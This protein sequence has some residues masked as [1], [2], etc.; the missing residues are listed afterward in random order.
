MQ[1]LSLWRRPVDAKKITI[2]RR[3]TQAVFFGITGTWLAVGAL[4]CPYGIPFISCQSCPSTDCPGR[5]LQLP[6]IGLV[7]LSG[8]LFGRA[9]CGWVCPMGFLMDILGKIP[10]LRFTISERFAAVDRYLKPL[11]YV[12]L[13]ATVYLVFALNYPVDRPYDYVVR[14]ESVFNMEAIRIGQLLGSSVYTVHMW[15]LIGALVGGLVIS[16]FWCRYLCP[17][18]ALLGLLNKVSLFGIIREREDLPRCALYPRDCNMHTMPGTTDCIVC[19]EC[20]EACPRNILG[21]RARYWGRRGAAG[22]ETPADEEQ[23]PAR[24]AQ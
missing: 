9:F 15:I 3:I 19:G 20:V 5:Y 17:L 7:A 16:R 2:W 11:K 13:A 6:F 10:K 12:S 22:D 8:V 18:G 21:L 14:T 23:Q 24:R 4:R 1:K